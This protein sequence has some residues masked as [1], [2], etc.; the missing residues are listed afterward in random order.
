MKD[1]R[2]DTP[3]PPIV[4]KWYYNCGSGDHFPEY[5]AGK[6]VPGSH[7]GL[8]PRVGHYGIEIIHGDDG[9]TYGM[10]C[11]YFSRPRALYLLAEGMHV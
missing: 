10:A 8:S 7:Y 11:D 4:D 6:L 1:H 3:H 5:P 2:H 9:N